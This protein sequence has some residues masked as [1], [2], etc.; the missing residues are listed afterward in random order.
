MLLIIHFFTLYK[1][2][3][4]SQ[5]LGKKPFFNQPCTTP[6]A[7]IP[8][9]YFNKYQM[10]KRSIKKHLF[11]A[12][13]LLQQEGNIIKQFFHFLFYFKRRSSHIF[14]TPSGVETYILCILYFPRQLLATMFLLNN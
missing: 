11:Y 5:L 3:F 9:I 4:L 12:H 6:V 2:C 1:P 7:I 13:I 14:N 10:N 8:G